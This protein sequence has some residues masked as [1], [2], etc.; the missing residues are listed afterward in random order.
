MLR[1]SINVGGAGDKTIGAAL[2]LNVWDPDT[3]N[4]AG[5]ADAP[6]RAGGASRAA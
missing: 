6:G 1:F 5:C 2:T 3:A 4:N